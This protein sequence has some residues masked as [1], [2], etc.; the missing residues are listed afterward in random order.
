M[1]KE[2]QN[3]GIRYRIGEEEEC[4]LNK[5]NSTYR[6]KP[7]MLT[8]TYRGSKELDILGDMTLSPF[9]FF[10]IDVKFIISHIEMEA[11]GCN[12][13]VRFN[14]QDNYLKSEIFDFKD[15]TTEHMEVRVN[16]ELSL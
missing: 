14:L 4:V 8:I 6:P 10:Y 5:E 3:N 11:D 15:K 9:N 7:D 12:Y 16:R 13:T 2:I 1:K